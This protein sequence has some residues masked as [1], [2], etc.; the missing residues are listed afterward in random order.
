MGVTSPIQWTDSTV[1]PVTGC[2]GCELHIPGKGGP[3]YAGHLHEG[4]L[5]R[6]LPHLY[7]ATF[8]NV[9]LAPGRMAEAAAWPDLRGKARPGKPWI[10]PEMPRL[11]FV[12]D[13]GDAL[14][15]AVPFEYLHDELIAAAISSKGR[16][17]IYQWLTKRPSRMAEFG[18]WLAEQ[19]V[20]WPENLWAGTSVT[21]Q[22]HYRRIM[23][24][25]KVPAAVRFLSLEPLTEAFEI[26]LAGALPRDEYP[27]YRM[28]YDM[29]HWVI[30]G[31][32]SEQRGF[33]PRAFDLSWA[34]DLVAECH[35]W[36]VSAFVKQLGSHPMDTDAIDR[37]TLPEDLR[38]DRDTITDRQLERL[39]VLIEA[40]T[41]RLRDSHG[42]CWEEWPEELRVREFPRVA[43]VAH[44]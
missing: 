39:G 13:M 34:R 24:L 9:R 21:G 20:E 22:A 23:E 30:L 37:A 3:C 4:R 38:V 7:D 42:G 11:I 10:P 14:S 36:G 12:S 1:N 26:G 5:A 19:G 43:G 44:A 27:G 15:R 8:T 18:R 31:G 28:L 40:G 32:E 33:K 2:D 17:H 29:I 6:S 35:S 16:R 41:V 25:G